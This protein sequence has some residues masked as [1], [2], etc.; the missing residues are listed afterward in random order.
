MKKIKLLTGI[1]SLVFIQIFIL[2]ACKD[3][4]TINA[5]QYED[6]NSSNYVV[7]DI[8]DVQNSVEDATLDKGMSFNQSF[9]DFGFMQQ[10][11]DFKPGNGPLRGNP[12]FDRFDFR[13]H[14][15]R[16]F[17]DLNLT[18][19]QKLSIKGLM[20][21]YHD[22]VKTYIDKFKAANQSIIDNANEQRKA[23]IADVKDS[24]IT[25]EEAKIKLDFLNRETRDKIE[26]N[27][28]TQTIKADMCNLTKKLFDDISA[29][30]DADQLTKWN[31][32]IS[33]MPDPCK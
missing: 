27:P 5:P 25:R 15:G 20:E 2:S 9:F 17:H 32:F 19:D 1:F 28:E 6:F 7:F 30:F 4:N 29:S 22:S 13:K 18:D 11:A 3:K 26:N 33:K 24:V 12:W 31:D 23:I 21:I 10:N 16:I 8:T 14:L